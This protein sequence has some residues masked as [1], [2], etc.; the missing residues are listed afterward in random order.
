MWRITAGVAFLLLLA[1]PATPDHPPASRASEFT[2]ARVSC[3]YRDY[4]KY[5]PT[6]WPDNPPWHHDYPYSDR[7]ITGMLQELTSIDATSYRIVAMD[8][9]EI[10]KYPF[11]Y[12]SEPGF[13]VLTDAEI[14]NLGEYIRRGGFIMADDFRTGV[15][16]G[17][18]DELEVLRNYLERA[19]PEYK[20]VRLDI[21]NPI[22]HSF[23]DIDTLD[24]KPPYGGEVKEFVPEFWG[25]VDE[26][27]RVRLIADYNN[28]LSEFW[29]WVDQGKMEFHPAARAVELG[30]NYVT[31]AMSH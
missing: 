9:P 3:S 21:H 5:W 8:S 17:G 16:L 23:Y 25:L 15:Y 13:M 27:G 2:F 19:V 1:T 22:F 18:P 24:M 10:F 12:L 30:V 14:A 7:F 31:Y 11:L 20:F 6:Y 26:K 28:D 4:L 29:K